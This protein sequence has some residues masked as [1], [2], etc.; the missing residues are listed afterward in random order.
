MNIH[1]DES[2]YDPRAVDVEK[3]PSEKF[4]QPMVEEDEEEDSDEADQGLRRRHTIANE[5]D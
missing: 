5:N 3:E 4:D 1:V 2:M